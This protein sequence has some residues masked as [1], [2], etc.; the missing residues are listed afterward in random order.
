MTN[1]HEQQL[2]VD[3]P[4]NAIELVKNTYGLSPKHISL[5]KEMKITELEICGTDIDACCMAVA[6]NLFD[7][8]IKPIILSNLCATSSSNKDIYYNSLDIMKRQFGKNNIQ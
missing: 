4:N 2:I 3:L 8:N 1:Q 7:N 5:L 6:F